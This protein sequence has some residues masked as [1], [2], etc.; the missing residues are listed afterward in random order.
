MCTTGC[1]TPGVHRS[2]GACLRAKA[3]QVGPAERDPR[4]AGDR[5]L[6][7]YYDARMQGIQPKGT[8][9]SQVQDAIE[10]ADKTQ[11]GDPWR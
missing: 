1:P 11:V 2:W 10:F 7:A 3:L 8:R 6:R 9:L 4:I 5:E